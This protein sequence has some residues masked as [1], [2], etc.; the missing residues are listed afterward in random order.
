MATRKDDRLKRL[1]QTLEPDKPAPDFI[2]R[3]MQE[4]R[5][6]Q[7]EELNPALKAVLQGNV[8]EKPT[9]D[10]TSVVIAQIAAMDQQLAERP[11][12]SKRA[13]YAIAA[14]VVGVMVAIGFT[15]GTASL[16][17]NSATLSIGRIGNSLTVFFVQVKAIPPLYILTFIAISLLLLLDYLLKE[18]MPNQEKNHPASLNE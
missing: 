6:E 3:V 13:W 14:F 17:P 8:V 12:I 15:S 16:P 9:V 5:M 2:G 18:K 1:I 10:F 11:I 7:Q 4:I